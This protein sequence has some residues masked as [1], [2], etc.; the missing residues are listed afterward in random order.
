MNYVLLSRLCFFFPHFLVDWHSERKNNH[1][2]TGILPEYLAFL[3]DGKLDDEK[4]E[5]PEQ[6]VVH[7]INLSGLWKITDEEF[8]IFCIAEKIL[9]KK[10]DRNM[11]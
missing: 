2:Y 3:T 10:T 11:F 1:F 8:E 9:K 4:Q 7:A 6:K 5:L